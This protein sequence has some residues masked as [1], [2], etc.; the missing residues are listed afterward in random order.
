MKFG[1]IFES[2]LENE[3]DAMAHEIVSHYIT[4]HSS[5]YVRW[6]AS[7]HP[8]DSKASHGVHADLKTAG[9]KAEPGF[10]ETAYSSDIMYSHPESTKSIRI[11]RYIKDDEPDGERTIYHAKFVD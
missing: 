4:P 8:G 11:R 2:S 7:V 10:G 3:T 9:W 6:Y 5:N 1:N